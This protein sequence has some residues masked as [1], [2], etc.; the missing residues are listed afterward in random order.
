VGKTASS[1]VEEI[2][3]L[4]RRDQAAIVVEVLDT[5]DDESEDFDDEEL[6]DELLRREAEGMNGSVSWTD[7]RDM[8]GE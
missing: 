2:K 8:P 4:S 5:L 7:L 3:K 6:L 1:L